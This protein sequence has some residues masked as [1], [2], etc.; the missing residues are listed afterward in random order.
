MEDM[1]YDL[2]FK[3]PFV[4]GLLGVFIA[5]MCGLA[6]WFAFRRD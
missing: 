5:V 6:G 2:A 4:Y 1:F 3:Y